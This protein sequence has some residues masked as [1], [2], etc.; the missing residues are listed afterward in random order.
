MCRN[1]AEKRPRGEP[2]EQKAWDV[3][4]NRKQ[5]KQEMHD[6][7]GRRLEGHDLL[8]EEV[9]ERLF[10]DVVLLHCGDGWEQEAEE[11]STIRPLPASDGEWSTVEGKEENGKGKRTVK[12]EKVCLKRRRDRLVIR[13]VVGLEIRVFERLLDRQTLFRVEGE[14]LVEEIDGSRWC[15]WVEDRERLLLPERQCSVRE[16]KRRAEDV[17][18]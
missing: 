5:R 6:R 10:R 2:N 17:R 7:S 13:V 1:R 8:V 12:V 16:S 15:V 14:G 18:P 9:L 4:W 11:A 3:A